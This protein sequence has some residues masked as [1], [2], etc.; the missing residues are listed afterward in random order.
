MRT[1]DSDLR[2]CSGVQNCLPEFTSMNRTVAREKL[3]QR[4]I[5][6][7]LICG[8]KAKNKL[9]NERAYLRAVVV[10][11]AELLPAGCINLGRLV[12]KTTTAMCFQVDA[13]N[14]VL[15]TLEK[16]TAIS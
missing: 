10:F 12:S 14:P 3:L 11:W 1:S 7:I 9:Q 4:A 6:I 2:V 8:R 15:D 16:M 5:A 13:R